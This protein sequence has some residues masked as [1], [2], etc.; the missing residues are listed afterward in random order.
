MRDFSDKTEVIARYVFSNELGIV[1]LVA[2][3]LVAGWL[4]ALAL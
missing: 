1:S 3:G 4:I 2:S